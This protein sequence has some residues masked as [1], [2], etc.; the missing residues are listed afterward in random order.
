MYMFIYSFYQ[1]FLITTHVY[2]NHVAHV[3]KSCPKY[4]WVKSRTYTFE[5]IE[6][7]AKLLDDFL[8]SNKSNMTQ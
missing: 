5:H 2:I 4:E 8:Y 7:P 1:N 3:D 6:L